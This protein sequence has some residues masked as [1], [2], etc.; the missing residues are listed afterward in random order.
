SPGVWFPF[1]ATILVYD[2][3]FMREDGKHIVGSS[4][5]FIVERASLQPQYDIGF[6]QN[7]EFPNGTAVYEIEQGEIVKSYV[8]GGGPPVAEVSATATSLFSTKNLLLIANG[9]V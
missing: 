6:F 3:S 2:T 8:Q 1:R 7:V 9:L 5:T 4:E